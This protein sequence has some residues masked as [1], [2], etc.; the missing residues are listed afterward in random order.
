[1]GRWGISFTFDFDRRPFEA[2]KWVDYRLNS[3]ALCLRLWLCGHGHV[4]DGSPLCR[5]LD[6]GD[7]GWAK[8]RGRSGSSEWKM[9]RYAWSHDRYGTHLNSR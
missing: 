5:P 2:Q 7:C 4:R 9:S 6:R 3:A 1:M 8:G